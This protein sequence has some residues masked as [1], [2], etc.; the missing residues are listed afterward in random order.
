MLSILEPPL[1]L[2]A[3]R[4]SMAAAAIAGAGTAAVSQRLRASV[5]EERYRQS[6]QLAHASFA[7][8]MIVL[9][10]TLL[11]SC[12][13]ECG[14]NKRNGT[15]S[16]VIAYLLQLVQRALSDTALLEIV[17]RRIH[18]LL[19]DLLVDIALFLSIS[20]C[21][22]AYPDRRRGGRKHTTSA[23]VMIAID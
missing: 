18:H 5:C 1:C 8:A 22:L 11:V 12:V 23:F 9:W 15:C 13:H 6:P 3:L 19:D 4:A 2:P 7:I 20:H 10:S 14:S 17:L 21:N 16:R